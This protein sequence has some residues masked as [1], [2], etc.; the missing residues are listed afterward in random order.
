MSRLFGRT[1]AYQSAFQSKVSLLAKESS[2]LASLPVS[3]QVPSESHALSH[4]A[5]AYFTTTCGY[6][7][8]IP[9]TVSTKHSSTLET[10]L[11]SRLVSHPQTPAIEQKRDFWNVKGPSAY[12]AAWEKSVTNPDVFWD[13][14]KTA[15]RW[16][17]PYDKV[18]EQSV[19]APS[20]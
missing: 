19:V 2:F 8:T 17:K 18:K 16:S 10:S 4:L 20:R 5:A 11:T 1:K 6:A 3:S 12:K 13:N 15:L 9:P 7:S 14:A